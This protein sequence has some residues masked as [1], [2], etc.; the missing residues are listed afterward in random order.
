MCRRADPEALRTHCSVRDRGWPEKN[1]ELVTQCF[2]FLVN[3][4]S[5]YLQEQ[6]HNP[7]KGFDCKKQL[8][9]HTFWS[10]D[11]NWKLKAVM[12][13]FLFTHFSNDTS[14]RPKPV[15]NVWLQTVE[16]TR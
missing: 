5:E 9:M 8:L 14:C 13:S 3:K 16:P 12:Q 1:T 7:S 2:D 6:E 10:G 4:T 11:M 15:L